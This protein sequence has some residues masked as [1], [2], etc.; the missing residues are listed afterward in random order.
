MGQWGDSEI[1]IGKARFLRH[2]TTKHVFGPIQA[3][4]PVTYVMIDDGGDPAAAEAALAQLEAGSKS[5]VLNWLPI[6]QV[7]P[8]PLRIYLAKDAAGLIW[9]LLYSTSEDGRGEW[10]DMEAGHGAGLVGMENFV[11]LADTGEDYVW[12]QD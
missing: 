9:L 3:G 8:I 7:T 1:R 10:E 4:D 11:S 2:Y 12:G 5:P 6:S